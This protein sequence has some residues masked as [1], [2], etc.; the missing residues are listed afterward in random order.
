MMS[1]ARARPGRLRFSPV[2]LLSLAVALVA[3]ALAPIALDY[4]PLPAPVRLSWPLLSVLFWVA[5]IAV[6]HFRF[7]REAHSFSM[8][9]IPMILG[10]FVSSPTDLLVAHLLGGGV[11]LVANRRQPPVKLAFNLSQFGLQ[12]LASVLA[13]RVVAGAAAL[14]PDR[15]RAWAA[16]LAASLVALV[17]SDVLIN[18]AIRLSGGRLSPSETWR[19]RGLSAVAAVMNT[20]L[21]LVVVLVVEAFPGAALLAAIP[22]LML[23]AASRAYVNQSLE[24]ARIAALHRATTALL[25]ASS[26]EEAVATGAREAQNLFECERVEAVLFGGDGRP[27]VRAVA[28]AGSIT[29]AAPP[30]DDGRWSPWQSLTEAILLDPDESRGLAGAELEIRQALL[31]PVATGEGT[32]GALLILNPLSDVVRF[33]ESDLRL[34]GAFGAQ[35]SA[36]V[37]TERLGASLQQMT[38]LVASK[39]SVLAAVSH[40]VRAPLATVVAA[41]ETLAMRADRLNED[42]RGELLGAIRR[43]GRELSGIVEDLV[44]AARSDLGEESIHRERVDVEAEVRRMAA[45]GV[46][47]LKGLEVHGECRPALADPLRLR[48]VVR[49]LLSNAARYGGPHAWIELGGALD[50]VVVAVV[51][52]G[53][54]VPEADAERIFEPYQSAHGPRPDALGLGLAIARRL[55]RLMGGDV[56]YRRVDELSR[57]EVELPA[58]P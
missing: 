4:A 23:F 27:A 12:T 42:Q 11:A 6:L 33:G 13:F 44:V 8:S 1:L 30:T 9:E 57:F 35:V 20:A 37:E 55:T 45:E 7:R 26:L 41:A 21:G 3:L 47:G 14:T 2:W 24:Q 49:N 17:T 32:I 50:R 31:A 38:Q 16:A 5:E 46:A 18:A 28:G 43:H 56:R 15:P 36:A 51:D 52:D 54:G 48:Q 19:V 10:L 22:P 29:R 34:A 40:E 53:A 25:H 39:N 58:A